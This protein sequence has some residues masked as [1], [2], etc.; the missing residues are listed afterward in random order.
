MT[1][2]LAA[3]LAALALAFSG[4]ALAQDKNKMEKG[5]KVSAPQAQVK[6]LH[7]N[8]KVRVTETTY[9]PGAESNANRSSMRVVRALSG[10][11][12]QRIHPDG[13]KQDIVWKTGD[14]RINNPS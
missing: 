12:L 11:T 5:S 8:D 2:I 1:K 7:E 4:A 10:G 13:K 6:V 9:A 3:S 14:V